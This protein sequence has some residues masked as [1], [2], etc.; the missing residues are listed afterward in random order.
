M[1]TTSVTSLTLFTL[2]RDRIDRSI[3]RRVYAA[4]WHRLTFLLC[5]VRRMLLQ[6][7]EAPGTVSDRQGCG[8]AVHVLWHSFS[9]APGEVAP[10]ASVLSSL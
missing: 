3:D 7:R 4:P 2:L 8:T 5:R 10:T 1:K 6:N 9:L